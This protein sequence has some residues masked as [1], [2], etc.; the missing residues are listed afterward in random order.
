MPNPL[1]V[2]PQQ[3]ALSEALRH[4]CCAQ[5]RRDLASARAALGAASLAAMGEMLSARARLAS[6]AGHASYAHYCWGEGRLARS[7]E[8]ARAQPR[9]AETSRD[10]PRPASAR[11]CRAAEADAL[12]RAGGD[13]LRLGRRL[14]RVS[15]PR[16]ACGIRMVAQIDSARWHRVRTAARSPSSRL[17]NV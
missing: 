7:P 15:R 17:K 10:Q 14:R 1:L 9:P 13:A 6:A 5:S 4:C 2:P 11:L 16:P 3:H 12:H 8:A